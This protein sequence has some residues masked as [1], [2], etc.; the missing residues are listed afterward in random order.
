MF[1]KTNGLGIHEAAQVGVAQSLFLGANPNS[2]A[3]GP[4]TSDSPSSGQPPSLRWATARP[5]SYKLQARRFITV[6]KFGRMPLARRK[7]I[8]RS[9]HSWQA[10]G[11]GGEKLPACARHHA[12]Q[13]LATCFDSSRVG[14]AETAT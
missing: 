2:M 9:Y 6:S 14:F 3:S 11:G 8:F 12:C 5:K 13:S 4:R 10:V 7:Q 1:M